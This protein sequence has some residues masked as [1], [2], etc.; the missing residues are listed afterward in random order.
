MWSAADAG[1]VGR[2]DVLGEPTPR[3]LAVPADLRPVA[4]GTS[5][6]GQV[7]AVLARDAPRG[8][9]LPRFDGPAH[10]ARWRPDGPGGQ[11]LWLSLARFTL[12]HEIDWD[13]APLHSLAFARL[14][15]G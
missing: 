12:V 2:I 1:Y 15:A 8:E 9:G 13:I 6:W 3:S 7:F 10:V 11:G 14:G 4:V 5:P